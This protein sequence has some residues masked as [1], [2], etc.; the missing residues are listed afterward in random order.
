MD[1]GESRWYLVL[2]L[3]CY[4]TLNFNP[5]GGKKCRSEKTG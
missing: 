2:C 5:S 4:I 3:L 1:S